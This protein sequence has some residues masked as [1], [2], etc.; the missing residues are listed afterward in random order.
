LLDLLVDSWLGSTPGIDRMGQQAAGAA[1]REPKLPSSLQPF[2]NRV[3][4][5]VSRPMSTS[6]MFDRPSGKWSI[7][8]KKSGRLCR[9]FSVIPMPKLRIAVL[10]FCSCGGYAQTPAALPSISGLW[11][12]AENSVWIQIDENGSAYQC[13]IGKEGTVYSSMGAFVAPNSI[14]WRAI[15]GVDKISARSGMMLLEG[16]YGEFEFHRTTKA[17][18]PS[19]LPAKQRSGTEV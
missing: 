3:I 10:A 4:G 16:P 5:H 9:Q 17:I 6:R 1:I 14:E 19:C 12:F 7:E 11:Q 15:W 2:A 13:R 8:L 18:S